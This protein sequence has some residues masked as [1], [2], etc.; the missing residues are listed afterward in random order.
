MPET[1]PFGLRIVKRQPE[2]SGEQAADHDS[3]GERSI[4]IYDPPRAV[5]A[6]TRSEELPRPEVE[7]WPAEVTAPY[8]PR[9]VLLSEPE[10]P[11]A[12]GFERMLHRL[13]RGP[14]PRVIVVTSAVAGE[15]KSTTAVNL[16]HAIARER[17]AR[18]LL[19]EANVRA[20]GLSQM[21]GFRPPLCFFE[22]LEDPAIS[23]RFVVA[24][25]TNAG[26]Y[27]LG[28]DAG[29]VRRWSAHRPAFDRARV[30]RAIRQLRRVY[31][32]VII[33]TPSA[34]ES[35]DASLLSDVADGI[36]IAAR[37]RRS[38]GRHVE[39]L[40]DQF[41][42]APILGIALLDAPRNVEA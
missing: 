22:Q 33:D 15:G 23:D 25:V 17:S 18:A 20:P 26:F 7:S 39:R 10:S 21:F 1:M 38:R 24:H 31:D 14:D 3:N 16:A 4:V 6:I 41:Q 36:V 9:L 42:P 11:R 34:L 2:P 29:I 37:A 13:R 32:Y 28:I 30:E 27:Y 8:D 19:L 12:R 35:P 40:L 5:H